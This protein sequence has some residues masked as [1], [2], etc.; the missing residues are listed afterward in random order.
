MSD[1]R[2]RALL[3]AGLLLVLMVAVAQPS[4]AI[5]AFARQYNTS[6][7]TC[8]SNFPKLN[9]FG[10]AFKDAGFKFPKDDEDFIKVPAVLLGAPAQKEN[11]PHTI[12]PGSIPGLPPIGLRYNTSFNYVSRNRGNFQFAGGGAYPPN[13]IPRTDFQ[14]GLF[15]IFTGGNFGSDIAFWVDDDFSVAGSEANGGLGD[16]YLKFVNIGRVIHLP[17]DFLS[18]RVGQFELDLPFTQAR[19]YNISG[20]D[21]YTQF[22]IGAQST[23]FATQQQFVNN[24]FTMDTAG[25]GVEISGGHQYGGYHY[26]IAVINQT[27]G[28]QPIEGGAFV[29]PSPFTGYVSD[30]NFKDLYARFS[31]RFNLE[32]DA[33]SRNDVQAAGPTGPRDHTF[34]QLGTYYFYGRSVQRVLGQDTL[35]NPVGLTAREPFYRV[36]G[37][38][39]FNYR[40][41]NVYGLYMYGHD[42]NLLPAFLG[43]PVALPPAIPPTGFVAG[44]P[45]TFSG[46]FVQADWLP[47][48]WMMLIMRYDGVNST[49]D[50]INGFTVLGS[51]TPYFSPVDA[52]RNR[53]TPGVQFLI[54]ANIKASFEYQIRP[55]Q[56]VIGGLSPTTGLPV[57]I[58]HF[59]TNAAVVVLEWVY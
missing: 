14:P 10:K 52:T 45:A 29:S 21:I 22:N 40:N 39:N 20:Y 5:P 57:D 44:T 11:F 50:R 41:F 31:Y 54:H 6:C 53:F 38:F 43:I 32:R 17:K 23:P 28:T 19:S 58:P 42:N 33:A 37:D 56:Q 9:D 46:G 36:G 24:Q 25:N 7:S 16:G 59:R 1:T 26:S 13:F 55:E 30:A 8:H 3:F 27:T 12:W 15:S 2:Y 4:H 48:P 51:G 34:L 18:M 47:Y 49:A 35:G